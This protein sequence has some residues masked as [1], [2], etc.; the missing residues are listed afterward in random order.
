MVKGAVNEQPQKAFGWAA[1]DPSGVLSPFHFS[2]RE[3]GNDDVTVKI[4]YC[5]VCHSD[6]HTLKNEWGFTK[7]P[8]LP[9]HEI[10]G[11]VTAVGCSVHKFKVGD[12]VGVG[13]IVGSC[14]TCHICE[15][16]LENYCPKAI[17]TYNSTDHDGTNTYGGYSD[18]IVVHQRF[19]LQFPE[20]LPSDAGAPLL[21]AGITVYSPMK[22]YGMTEPGKHLGIAGLGGLGHIAVKIGKAFGLKVTV[23]STSPKK[24]DEAITKL[25]ADAFVLST[26]PVKFKAAVNT[27]DYIIDTIAAV[28]P[29][30]PL[31]SLLKMDGKLI[32]IGLP[33]KPLELPIFPLVLG[34]KLVGGSDIGGMKET[35]E[36]LDFCAKHNITA[37]I[38][39]ISV[40]NINMAMERLAKSDVKYRFVIDI[41]NSLSL[42]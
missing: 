8:I 3:N 17:F 38:E 9:G 14:Q 35:Q 37:D 1:R 33:E 25:G 7:Y 2:R 15:Q 21:C 19:V 40:D 11:I 22:Y 6:L 10:V 29:L 26:D 18:I 42:S 12:R 27:M 41:A 39:L 4:H 16:S 34:R 32:T 24:E 23:I 20:N 31:L 30:A 28:H 36:M 5:G 13:V